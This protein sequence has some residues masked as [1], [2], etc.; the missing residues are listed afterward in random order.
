MAAIKEENVDSDAL[1]DE[2]NVHNA[3]RQIWLLKLPKTLAE[4]WSK[5]SPETD[6]GFIIQDKSTNKISLTLTGNVVSNLPKNYNFVGKPLTVEEPPLAV[7]SQ[8]KDGDVAMEGTIHCRGD[9]EPTDALAREYRELCRR[10][11]EKSTS[12]DREIKVIDDKAAIAVK[13]IARHY[14]QYKAHQKTEKLKRVTESKDEVLNR[15]FSA[16]AKSP[17]WDLKSLIVHTDQPQATLKE[18]LNE[19]CVY[20]KRGPNRLMYELKEQYKIKPKATTTPSSSSFP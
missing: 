17:Y 12:K 9:L 1:L 10:R 13:P 16:F 4:A 6:L 19:V 8:S 14:I 7:F 2:L 15:I 3:N 18:V 20:N 11:L 5:A